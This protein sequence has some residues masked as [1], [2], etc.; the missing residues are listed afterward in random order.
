M[1]TYALLA[2]TAL[3]LTVAP[4]RADDATDRA[5]AVVDTWLAAQN[6]GKFAD[7]R[8]LYA[9]GF[10]GVRRSGAATKRLD[11][12]GWLR[13]RKRMFAH[14]MTVAID[15]VAFEPVRGGVRVRFV[16]SFTQGAYH[17][18][19]NK[20]L[21]I[22]GGRIVREEMLDSSMAGA[23]G[24][25]CDTMECKHTSKPEAIIAT[26]VKACDGGDHMACREH[27]NAYSF[28]SCGLA[29][30]A[31]KAAALYEK[32]CS[33]DDPMSCSFAADT[34]AKTDEAKAVPL[35]RRACDEG[36][37]SGC[38]ALGLIL[39]D[40]KTVPHDIKTAVKMLAIACNDFDRSGPGSSACYELAEM[41]RTGK[42]V[43]KNRSEAAD[44]QFKYDQSQQGE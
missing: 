9:R 18:T 16:Q 43:K 40:S 44:W 26:C 35:Y 42:G 11:L 37:P 32:A 31:A 41:Y 17:D 30:D 4:A 25:V 12:K 27:A 34:Y 15:N 23:N 5:K 21:V 33:A 39:R 13:D 29:L 24:A 19:G 38:Y 1:R 7:Y 10:R 28:G 14:P 2:L 20:E 6:G 3:A 8:A 22:E 36:D